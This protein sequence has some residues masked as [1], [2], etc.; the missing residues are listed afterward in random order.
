MNLDL[1]EV[2]GRDL[3]RV[4]TEL[5]DLLPGQ[6]RATHAVYCEG[7]LLVRRAAFGP[8]LHVEDDQNRSAL[9]FD[10]QGRALVRET[11][12]EAEAQNRLSDLRDALIQYAVHWGFALE[13]GGGGGPD[14]G[15]RWRLLD[16]RPRDARMEGSS[17]GTLRPAGLGGEASMPAGAA[18]VVETS[19]RDVALSLELTLP[20]K[21]AD[22]LQESKFLIGETPLSESWIP[23]LPSGHRVSWPRDEFDGPAPV[24]LDLVRDG[25][26]YTRFQTPGDAGREVELLVALYPPARRSDPIGERP[27]LEWAGSGL[28]VL[29]YEG[30][31]DV[32]RLRATTPLDLQ[33]Q[34][35]PGKDIAL[36]MRIDG[37]TVPLKR[38][39]R[40]GQY[41]AAPGTVRVYLP[42]WLPGED[43]DIA[44]DRRADL[45]SGW[46]RLLRTGPRSGGHSTLSSDELKMVRR[47]RAGE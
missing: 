13:R 8:K 11:E 5:P 31:D 46:L 24:D 37:V 27:A 42:E 33:V 2:D 14:L 6:V 38:I 25:G 29:P 3:L 26:L 41:F 16:G 23:R 20:R 30:R 28:E 36:C 21:H 17:D 4:P 22:D 7:P 15:A 19:H 18:L 9:G 45:P 35:S 47:L 12:L 10:R 34:E 44:G 40:D 39:R 32:V 43:M 1:G